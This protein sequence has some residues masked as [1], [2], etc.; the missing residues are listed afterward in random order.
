MVTQNGL[1]KCADEDVVIVMMVIAAVDVMVPSLRGTSVSGRPSHD[2]GHLPRGSHVSGEN[3]T[4]PG[5]VCVS[6]RV[7]VCL[8]TFP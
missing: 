5:K 1:K 8:C 2:L 4:S 6:V 3:S 7:C